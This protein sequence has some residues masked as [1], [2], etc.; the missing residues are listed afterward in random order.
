MADGG[1]LMHEQTADFTD[2]RSVLERT[3]N[4]SHQPMSRRCLNAAFNMRFSFHSC[5][6]QL[7]SVGPTGVN[8]LVR[9]NCIHTHVHLCISFACLEDESDQCR[10]IHTLRTNAVL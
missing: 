6:D 5:S 10:E 2:V 9:L 7:G 1:R 4:I 8:T 3:T